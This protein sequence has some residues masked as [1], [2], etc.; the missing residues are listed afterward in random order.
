MGS[1]DGGDLSLNQVQA[2]CLFSREHRRTF[3]NPGA[4]AWGL[5]LSSDV[6][7]RM[8]EQWVV[9][10]GTVGLFQGL[11]FLIMVLCVSPAED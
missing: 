7:K 3:Q 4:E 10:T 6:N 9:R 8:N 2:S 11:D 5:V 1:S